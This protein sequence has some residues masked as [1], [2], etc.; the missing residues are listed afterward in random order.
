MLTPYTINMAPNGFC[1]LFN[2][3]TALV[4]VR[5]NG[6]GI[7]VAEI[8]IDQ[9]RFTPSSRLFFLSCISCVRIFKYFR[10]HIV[11]DKNDNGSTIAIRR[12]TFS[13]TIY[14]LL[15]F[16]D[17]YF[18]F[19]LSV[20]C[21]LSV[22]VTSDGFVKWIE[23]PYVSRAFIDVK[24]TRSARLHSTSLKPCYLQ[25]ILAF[26]ASCTGR[27]GQHV[28]LVFWYGSVWPHTHTRFE[29][30]RLTNWLTL[31]AIVQRQMC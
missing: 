26:R 16:V 30:D 17:A 24:H 1:K 5:A 18:V 13:S 22:A 3:R 21:L 19:S 11:D 20:F 28:E 6:N 4:C 10:A 29:Y 8:I 23:I 25:F 27:I 9:R 14:L 12:T 31:A 2:M 15:I 7:S